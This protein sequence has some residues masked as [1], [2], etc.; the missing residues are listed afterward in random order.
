MSI[1]TTNFLRLKNAQDNINAVKES[2]GTV[3]D[4]SDGYHTFDELYFHRMVL[5]SIVFNEHKDVAWKAKKHHDGTMFGDNDM[6]IVG[7]E[8]PEGQYSYHYKLEHWD[9][10]DVPDLI[11]APEYDGHLPEDVPRLLTLAKQKE[12]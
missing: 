8:T 9:L 1:L 11:T 4:I 12:L 7:V 2:G 10:F 3:K 5:S 6:F